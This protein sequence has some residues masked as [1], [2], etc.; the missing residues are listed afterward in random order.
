MEMYSNKNPETKWTQI[1]QSDIKIEHSVLG[2]L[3][4]VVLRPVDMLQFIKSA[5][6]YT[7]PGSAK[8]SAH[9]GHRWLC[10]YKFH[11]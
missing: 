8:Q 3:N 1:Y 7:H 2:E 11:H 10:L 6:V 4:T 5:P 9:V